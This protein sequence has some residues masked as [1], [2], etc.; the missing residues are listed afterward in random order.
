MRLGG[1]VDDFLTSGTNLTC[2]IEV[3]EIKFLIEMTWNDSGYMKNILKKYVCITQKKKLCRIIN[4][5][6]A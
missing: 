3:H 4:I 5:Y 2:I 6:E 1:T